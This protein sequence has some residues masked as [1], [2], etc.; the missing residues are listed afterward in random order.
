[1]QSANKSA[2]AYWGNM[3]LHCIEERGKINSII[4]YYFYFTTI[5]I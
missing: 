4:I 2:S 5:I 1:M 3:S